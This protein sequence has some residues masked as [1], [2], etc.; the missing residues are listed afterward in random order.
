MVVVRQFS[1]VV[2]SL[3][4]PPAGIRRGVVRTALRIPS[5]TG[6]IAVPDFFSVVWSFSVVMAFSPGLFW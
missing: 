5:S 4:H 1:L 6:H 3:N 2:T